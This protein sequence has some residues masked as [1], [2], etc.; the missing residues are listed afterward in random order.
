MQDTKPRKLLRDE[1]YSYL[2]ESLLSCTIPPGTEIRAQELARQFDVSL[3]PVRDA[4]H[5]LQ[6]E[7]LIEV[8]PRQGYYARKISL[9]D[10][11]E[12]Y[13]MRI[14]LEGAC[15]ERAVRSASDADLALLDPYRDELLASSRREWIVHNREFHM[16]LA[17]LCGNSRLMSMTHDIIQAFDRLTMASISQPFEIRSGGLEA[18]TTFDHEHG[19][20]IDAVKGRDAARAVSL[21]RSHIELSRTRF[22]ESYNSTQA[23]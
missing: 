16:L 15:V 1:I 18:L 10:A 6:S 21:I 22:I 8:V 13:E 14:I 17:S 4:L 20:I 7:D 12:L 2:K 3:S 11:L 5:Q 19:D 9:G 23:G